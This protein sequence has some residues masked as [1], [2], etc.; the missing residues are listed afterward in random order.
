[1]KEEEIAVLG[2]DCDPP[3]STLRDAP[4]DPFRSDLLL[5]TKTSLAGPDDPMYVRDNTKEIT[6]MED[7]NK[8]PADED[9]DDDSSVDDPWNDPKDTNAGD[10]SESPSNFQ[11]SFNSVDME[12]DIRNSAI[13]TIA[14]EYVY[15]GAYEIVYSICTWPRLL[16]SYCLNFFRL[17]RRVDDHDDDGPIPPQKDAHV[18][19][20]AIAA[21]QSA[22]IGAG[23]GVMAGQSAAARA[24]ASPMSAAISALSTPTMIGLAVTAAIAVAV[25]TNGVVP[26][27]SNGSDN[28]TDRPG[29]C[30]DS[31]ESMDLKEGVLLVAF[32]SSESN[33]DHNSTSVAPSTSALLL[34]NKEELENIF[35]QV[36]NNVTANS[37]NTANGLVDPCDVPYIPENGVQMMQVKSSEE[38]NFTNTIWVASMLGSAC[39]NTGM[40]RTPQNLSG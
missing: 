18:K 38:D 21:S 7:G 22:A 20:M 39:L 27:I 31:T 23:A 6:M 40:H 29:G 17:A 25:S 12:R 24:G 10:M 26:G 2:P 5:S 28:N 30:N 13:Q 33:S 4:A 9:S 8:A 14:F 15:S 32:S 16:L 35:A 37:T 19:D 3:D 36:Y 1:M 34:E 11:Y